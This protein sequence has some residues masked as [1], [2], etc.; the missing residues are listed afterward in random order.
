MSL[1]TTPKSRKR[2]DENSN[3][4]A[5]VNFKEKEERGAKPEI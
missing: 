4:Y 5:M 1:R 3:I 2:H